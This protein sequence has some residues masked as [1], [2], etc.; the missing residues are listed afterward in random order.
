MTASLD[1]PKG[2]TH[3]ALEFLGRWFTDD[4][5][6]TLTSIIPD[7][8][9]TT[10]T[11]KGPAD[12]GLGTWIEERQGVENVYFTNAVVRAPMS[13]KPA[14]ENISRAVAW[15]CDVD[16]RAIEKG[17][18]PA[19]HLE[20]ERKRI[21]KM[22]REFKPAASV[23]IS[24]G[25]GFQAL[26]RLEDDPRLEIGGLVA[27]AQE[28]ELYNIALER[29]LQG[30]N[31]HNIDRI[32]RLPGTLNIPDRRKIKKGRT[33]TLAELVEFNQLVYPMSDF[34]PAVR[35]QAK[36]A[37]LTTSG[38]PKVKISGNVPQVGVEELQTW[39]AENNAKISDHTYA[40][41]ATGSDPLDPNKYGSRSEALFAVCCALVRA[42]VPEEMI[43]AVITGPNEIAASVKEKRNFQEYAQRQIARAMENAIDPALRELNE[44]HAVIGDIG[45]RCRIISEVMDEVLN[46]TRIS[47]STFEDF[48]NRYNNRK[49]QIATDKQGNP[50]YKPLGT[51]WTQHEARRQYDTIVFAP[52]REIENSYNLWQGFNCEALPGNKHEPLLEHILNN[53]CV[54]NVDHYNYLI[55]WLARLVQDPGSP[56]QV[57]V[58]MRGKRGTGKGFLV[59]QIGALFGRHYLQVSDSKHLT[60]SFNAHLRDVVLLFGD[61]AFFAGDKRHESVLKTLI[62]E[63]QIVIEGKGVDAES[64]LNY[65]H[66]FMASNEDWVVPTGLDE[67]RFFVLEVGD[68]KKQ[69]SGYFK[70]LQA[71][72]DEGGLE[73]LLH[74]LL[75][76]DVSEYEVRDVPQTRGLLDQKILSMGVDL[77]W[78]YER[79]SEGRLLK[80]QHQ[81]ETR[82]VKDILYDDYCMQARQA[83]RAAWNHTP[84]TFSR[85]LQRCCPKGTLDGSKQEM[86]DVPVTNPATGMQ[87]IQHRRA[88]VWRFPALDVL[89]D[90]WD[91]EMGG[92][93]VWPK[94]EGSQEDMDADEARERRERAPF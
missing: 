71:Q 20:A 88:Y 12:K 61:E 58:V 82:M 24:S 72:M 69:K 93:Y 43:Y 16:P 78:F 42:N 38:A 11:F 94:W 67:R 70:S 63:D 46:R 81:W 54:G 10:R 60:G 90:F 25:A 91:K 52:N 77:Q 50:V 27:K 55:G 68:D 92:P 6:I 23:I 56:G 19:Q 9:T 73:N 74:F 15:H 41:I 59:K 83:G 31:C 7:G 51:W 62:T 35:V 48:R 34:V 22:L 32:L 1:T 53:V 26:W 84:T 36:N 47:K 89:R 40:V 65:V 3:A 37:G 5:W 79:L 39:A 85:F 76:Y 44:K 2:D 29:A 14:K 66:L 86:C 57:A 4:A 13:S 33:V 64:A 17:V 45:G 21:L 87:S 75:S 8:K 49:V 80:T 28:L 18:D 30:D